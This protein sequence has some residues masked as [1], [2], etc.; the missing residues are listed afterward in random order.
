MTVNSN[1]QHPIVWC[2]IDL[3]LFFKSKTVID[4]GI[5][6]GLSGG[7]HN[8]P[9]LYFTSG[10]TYAAFLEEGSFPHHEYRTI[11]CYEHTLLKLN[12]RLDD[13][14]FH[15]E[16]RMNFADSNSLY[17][18][19][20]MMLCSDVESMTE[21]VPDFKTTE[22]WLPLVMHE[23]FHSFQ[24]S[25]QPSLFY[26]QNLIGMAAD[27]LSTYYLTNASFQHTLKLE[28]EL[29]IGCIK[30]ENQ[31][32]LDL[33]LDEFIKLRE[34]RRSGF[35][36]SSSFNLA[37]MEDFWE[38]IEGT[39]RYIEYYLAGKFAQ[40]HVEDLMGCDSLFHNFAMFKD[41]LPFEQKPHFIERTKIMPAYY[42]V[43]GFNIC[44]LLDKLE[45]E[46][47][48]NRFQNPEHSIYEI[49]KEYVEANKPS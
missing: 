16:N 18:F 17:F 45:L 22:D 9:L 7:D 34:Q 11:T 3:P 5:W 31:D 2:A 32:S 13:Q 24:F 28:N 27:T 19:R 41:S 6:P 14:P 29:L 21:F 20:P 44:R 1:Y 23:Y 15:M 48:P 33:Y 47:K 10:T 36:D 49:L 4:N 30:S 42:Y 43:T 35:A 46:Y 39:A 25:H 40:M 26:L 38:T 8:P 12:R 37:I